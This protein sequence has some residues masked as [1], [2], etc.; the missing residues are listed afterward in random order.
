MRTL[1]LVKITDTLGGVTGE[2]GKVTYQALTE[3]ELDNLHFMQ[4][5]YSYIGRD[6]KVETLGDVQILSLEE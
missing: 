1:H 3:E 4:S 5:D 6:F 2:R